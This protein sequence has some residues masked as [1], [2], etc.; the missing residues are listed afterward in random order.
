M[1]D[2]AGFNY[3]EVTDDLDEGSFSE[4]VKIKASRNGSRKNKRKEIRD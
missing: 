3:V 1:R 2:G 4:V